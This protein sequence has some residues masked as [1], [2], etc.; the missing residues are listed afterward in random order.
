MFMVMVHGAWS[1]IQY[2]YQYQIELLLH[3]PAFP[4][5]MVQVAGRTDSNVERNLNVPFSICNW[6]I[7]IPIYI[8][9]KLRAFCA[10][11]VSNGPRLASRVSPRE[12][13]WRALSSYHHDQSPPP[14]DIAHHDEYLLHCHHHQ[15][16]QQQQQ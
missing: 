2:S 5:K 12:H 15:Q 9:F 14:Y 3:T 10:H 7:L 6:V 8:K 1:F 4:P 11:Y 16:Q 13:Y